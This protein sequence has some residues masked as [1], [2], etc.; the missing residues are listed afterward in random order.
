MLPRNSL[1]MQ[2][3]HTLLNHLLCFWISQAW[4]CDTVYPPNGGQR[5][6][7]HLILMPCH[8]LAAHKL[9][10]P[11]LCFWAEGTVKPHLLSLCS[12]SSSCKETEAAIQ[13]TTICSYW[14]TWSSS[15]T[16]EEMELIKVWFSMRIVIPVIPCW[17]PPVMHFQQCLM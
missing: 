13:T 10:R 11:H 14:Y 4:Y 7:L 2:V 17:N 16:C 12:P 1:F 3:P 9:V 5:F 6:N 15:S 8:M